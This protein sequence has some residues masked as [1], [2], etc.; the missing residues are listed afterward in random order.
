MINK[1]SILFCISIFY[2]VSFTSCKKDYRVVENKVT[3]RATALDSVRDNLPNGSSILPIDLDNDNATDF[4]I[5]W[6]RNYAKG[7]QYLFYK[8]EI[9]LINFDW[10][11]FGQTDIDTVFVDTILYNNF[12]ILNYRNTTDSGLI[13]SIDTNKFGRL[14]TKADLNFYT[15]N[16]I[17][18]NLILITETETQNPPIPNPNITFMDLKRGSSKYAHENWLKFKHSNGS[19]KAIRLDNYVSSGANW[20]YHYLMEIMDL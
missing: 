8:M 14:L 11:V 17:N 12:A 13:S 16:L 5:I 1:L 7:N 20:P 15:G 19:I 6:N 3:S 2:V 18:D 4:N 10:S 9:E